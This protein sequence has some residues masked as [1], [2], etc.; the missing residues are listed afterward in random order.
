MLYP[1]A[2][3]DDDKLPA[4]NGSSSDEEIQATKV[5]KKKKRVNT[6]FSDNFTFSGADTQN[7]DHLDGLKK[8]LE[9]TTP[10]YLQMNIEKERKKLKG[11]NLVPGI[12]DQEIEVGADQLDNDDEELIQEHAEKDDRVREKEMKLPKKKSKQDEYF[13]VDS[14][15]IVAAGKQSDLT[16]QDMNLS[17]PILKAVVAA[18]FTTPTA[19]QAS[20][21]P[22]ALAG[23]DIC[24]CS[25]TGTGK[26]AAF[27]LPILERLLYKPKQKAQTRV[28]VLVPTR[29][30]AIQV[31]QVSRKLAEH[32]AVEI[33]LCAGGLDLK[34]Q[35][36]AL[37]LGLDVVI[38]TPGRLIDHLKNAPGFSLHGIEVLV[39]DE[40]DRMLDETFEDE[41]KEIIG[42]CSKNRQTMLFSATM[43]DEIEEL[44][45]LSL[46]KPVKLFINENSQTAE[47]LRQEFVRI[48]DGRENEREAITAA[49]VTRNF[50][51]H[52]IIFM[53]TKK[54]CARMHV[55]LGLLGVKCAQMHGNL[56]QTMR[57]QALQ[58]FKL[59]QV[60]VLVCTELA[61]RG[62][63][64]EGVMT[65]INMQ[66][67]DSVQ[68]YIH[69]VGRTARAG[70][71]GRAISL[72]GEGERKLLK[73]I[74]KHN[75]H[76][77]IKQRNLAPEVI[78]AY[79]ERIETLESS[80]ERVQREA[81]IDNQLRLTEDKLAKVEKKVLTGEDER[82][83]RIWMKSAAEKKKE[84]I[85]AQNALRKLIT[86]KEKQQKTPEDRAAEKEAAYQAR[87]IKKAHKPKRMRAFAEDD[88]KGKRNGKKRKKS[89]F[90]DHL[91]DTSSKAVK[92]FRYGPEDEGF[93]KAKQDQKKQG[94]LKNRRRN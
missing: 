67:P 86:K 81:V 85:K 92:K 16:F 46:Q 28:L 90:V 34:A 71:A 13:D 48:R 73:S 8:F 21:I 84:E 88:P 89:S 18:G 57:V 10:S 11:I 61:A 6:D 87:Q 30:L 75:Q 32:S 51:D 20:C 64:I 72:V 79:K 4:E 69:R 56:S 44:A 25:A 1:S 77:T 65:V 38:A 63:D 22:V 29:E 41:M 43:T 19:I 52:T 47:N 40:A 9:K 66:M 12:V 45:K 3:E 24:A 68:Q 74:V 53:K 91:T 76:S 49:L 60:D 33:C 23:R 31:F 35:E 39:L 62:L 59:Q 36:A 7:E 78:A 54:D 70:K 80:I 94:K 37:R 50:P 27:M 55:I 42:M 83:G 82:E 58:K 14:N 5:R 15:A 17:R 2:I 93:R 26:T